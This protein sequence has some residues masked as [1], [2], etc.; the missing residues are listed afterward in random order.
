MQNSFKI[1]ERFWYSGKNQ[2]KHWN[3]FELFTVE[4]KT[5]KKVSP[6]EYS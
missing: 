6:F 1:N 4:F 3:L 5:N 2:N